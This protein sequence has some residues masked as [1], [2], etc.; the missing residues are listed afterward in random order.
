MP[1]PVKAILLDQNVPVAVT[2]WL[3]QRLPEWRIAHVNPL[4]FAG[5]TDRFL[6]DWA[7]KNGALV[8]TFDED[9]AD[10]RLQTPGAHHGVIRLRVWPTTTEMAIR[11]LERL[12]ANLP[13]A[14]WAGG[15]IIVD[16]HRIR[17][18]RLQCPRP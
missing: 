4:G 9:F 1:D 12:M 2:A 8:I 18:R 15:L 7:Q 10:S 14:E 5:Q 17:V 11:A 13:P 6:F 16:N 3:A